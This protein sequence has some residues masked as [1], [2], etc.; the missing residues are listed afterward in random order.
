MIALIILYFALNLSTAILFYGMILYRMEQMS[1][2]FTPFHW[3]NI[4]FI[5][6]FHTDNKR[7]ALI[8]A[9]L[10]LLVGIFVIPFELYLLHRN[11]EPIKLK[12]FIKHQ[13]QN[14]I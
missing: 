2:K 11:S 5:K 4:E 13:Q 7:I 3:A 10:S 6:L 8:G 14:R 1:D 9:I 12:Y